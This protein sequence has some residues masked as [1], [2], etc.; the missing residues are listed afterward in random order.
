MA[1]RALKWEWP[2]F[3]PTEE[4]D[5]SALL[6]TS[7][8]NKPKVV[9]LEDF[10]DQCIATGDPC[11]KRSVV[12]EANQRLGL[13]ER[14]AEEM[15]DL[16][17]ERGLAS[18]IRAGSAMVYVKNRYGVAGD[19]ALWAAALL[20]RNPQANVQEIAK[21]VDI[22]QRYVRQIRNAMGGTDPEPAVE[23]KGL[24]AELDA[25]LELSSSAPSSGTQIGNL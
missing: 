14:K 11:S 18:R 21:Q 2:L 8:P 9:P 5:A 15:L 10:V 4:V 19:K 20:A 16:A 17:M 1:P 7:K 6:G 25:E 22:S 24:T 13:S 23:N 3:T 12:Y